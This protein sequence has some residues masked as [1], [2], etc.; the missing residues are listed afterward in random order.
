MILRKIFNNQ[1]GGALVQIMVLGAISAAMS[2]MLLK[3]NETNLK[4][5]NKQETDAN[6]DYFINGV[7]RDTLSRSDSC[8][9]TV[10]GITNMNISNSLAQITAR[11]GSNVV[12]VVSSGDLVANRDWTIMDMR[13]SPFVENEPG[14]KF[15]RCDLVL[16]VRRE[17]RLSFGARER[18]FTIPIYCE[19]RL[20]AGGN[21][22]GAI[23]NCMAASAHDDGVWKKAQG[24]NLAYITYQ[25]NPGGYISIGNQRLGG[26]MVAPDYPVT[27]NEDVA[28]WKFP[29][30]REGVNIPKESVYSFRDNGASGSGVWG[31]SETGPMTNNQDPDGC[32]SF[33]AFDNISIAVFPFVEM[34]FKKTSY[35]N[36]INIYDGGT[37]P[38]SLQV[39]LGNLIVGPGHTNY[40]SAGS[41]FNHD[42]NVT[43]SVVAGSNN[44][45]TLDRGY[46]YAFGNSNQV[47][48]Q[49]AMAVG[50]GNVIA[51]DNDV[52]EALYP[53]AIKES[54]LSTAIGV[55]N[56]NRSFGS[57]ALGFSNWVLS[58]ASIAI[59][60]RNDLRN[61][62]P[63]NPA[64]C[65][66]M[67]S[68]F[69]SGKF[70]LGQNNRIQTDSQ[71][72]FVFGMNNSIEGQG[73]I[74]GKYGTIRPGD[75]NVMIISAT[76]AG[77]GGGKSVPSSVAGGGEGTDRF[78]FNALSNMVFETGAVGEER[79]FVISNNH[80]FTTDPDILPEGRAN[81]S[82]PSAVGL[83]RTNYSV[84]LA[85]TPDSTPNFQFD[86]PYSAYLGLA[87]T[88]PA[89]QFRVENT[90]EVPIGLGVFAASRDVHIINGPKV[91]YGIYSSQD[92]G[93]RYTH[94]D[95]GNFMFFASSVGGD[96]TLNGS[97]VRSEA[98]NVKSNSFIIGSPAGCLNSQGP[99]ENEQMWNVGIL[100]GFWS[101]IFKSASNSGDMALNY[102]IGGH[103]GSITSL[104]NTPPGAPELQNTI[105]NTVINSIGKDSSV[106]DSHY[107]THC[108]TPPGHA[109]FPIGTISGGS[110]NTVIG[111]S[112]VRI[113]H[114]DSSTIIGGKD[115]VI[116]GDHTQE[117]NN[118]RNIIVNGR[119]ARIRGRVNDSLVIGQATIDS[120][121]GSG[122]AYSGIV[123]MAPNI[124]GLT[125][126][127]IDG[128]TPDYRRTFNAM[129][130]KAPGSIMLSTK[131]EVAG[132]GQ[133]ATVGFGGVWN[134]VSS[135]SKKER[136][137]DVEDYQLFQTKVGSIPVNRFQYFFNIE[138]ELRNI[139]GDISSGIGPFSE[140]FKQYFNLGNEDDGRISVLNMVGVASKSVQISMSQWEKLT[141]LINELLES[142]HEIFEQ[143]VAIFDESKLI[144][145]TFTHDS[146]LI[147]LEA[148]LES[149]EQ[150]AELV[151][152][153]LSLVEGGNRD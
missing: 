66:D 97:L 6:L 73:Y 39:N 22:T 29:V 75:S 64:D 132:T 127:H 37:N 3:V 53:G 13:L 58:P 146:E 94:A 62:N 114:S 56:Y 84:S 11:D 104:T 28:A 103:G 42:S 60:R 113:R 18:T 122:D 141:L 116:E 43:H 17:R 79:R 20:D 130:M 10:S 150:E 67:L 38:Q 33:Y 117:L 145:N 80:D 128:L 32:L 119:D 65:V 1:Y 112:N 100:G 140:D 51:L 21:L 36:T 59:G 27:I 87:N 88:Q 120:L 96:S 54:M 102:V 143:L 99:N 4:T 89:S 93:H 124:P 78:I 125:P 44:Q 50:R 74:F 83:N 148:E 52:K 118:V 95:T 86:L 71:N 151:E 72:N 115:S 2:T 131:H 31:V 121:A 133:T 136:I 41:I 101:S 82:Y 68:C 76:G 149:L 152:G 14:G 106:A 92:V 15:G 46:M 47:G 40:I 91:G 26:V 61:L 57:H 108:V 63:T 45:L 134:I 137:H 16:D 19:G 23:E 69:G 126:L 5:L 142:L 7:I 111:G 12:T 98:L 135:R 138:N 48:G 55:Q 70:A 8:S 24:T 90:R 25:D 129:Y 34:C 30:F 109:N 144:L 139:D 85:S 153:K 81:L 110:R 49:L 107:T 123:A 9:E 35:F 77:A 105:L 147:E